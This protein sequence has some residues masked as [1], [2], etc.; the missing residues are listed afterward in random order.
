M[1]DHMYMSLFATCG[2]ILRLGVTIALLMS[3]HPAL[4]LLAVF[5]VP[6]VFTSTWRPAV[7][8]QAYERG[9]SRSPPG[10]A[11]V[12]RSRRPPAPGKE[13]R[14]TGIGERLAA[15]R[16]GAWECG[17][18]PG[19]RRALGVGR[20]A[21]AG[22]GDLRRWAMSARSCSSPSGLRR[23][24]RRRAAGAGGRLAAVVLRRRHRRRD[25]VPA[26]RLDGFGRA[27]SPGS[28]TTRRRSP[29]RRS[30][31][32]RRA[33]TDGIR[34]E[35]VS[36][37]YPGTDRLVLDDVNLE[38]PAGSVVADRRRERR[39]QDHARQA[40]REDVRARPADAS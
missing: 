1:L 19:R 37:A 15:E 29:Q 9:A 35:H 12:R 18:P 8:R 13:V 34:F 23:A 22:V 39:R 14:V 2:W 5:A 21:H 36:F 33:S 25:R 30:C 4:A 20:V 6:P 31:R 26:R 7:E 11:S 16:R 32:R 24:G 3:I 27:G 40:A 10:A 38:L 17:Q 28:R